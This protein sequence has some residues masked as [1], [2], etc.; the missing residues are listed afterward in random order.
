M[1]GRKRTTSQ[2]IHGTLTFIAYALVSNDTS[3]DN[4]QWNDLEILRQLGFTPDLHATKCTSIDD[5]VQFAKKWIAQRD[6]Y[7]YPTDGTLL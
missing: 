3:G 7:S 2:H 4:A 5:V 6:T 1:I